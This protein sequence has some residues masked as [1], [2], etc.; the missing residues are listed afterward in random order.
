MKQLILHIPHSSTNIP[1]KDGYLVDDEFLEAEMLKLTD[2]HTDDLFQSEEDISIIANFSRVFC[3]PERFSDDEQ[4]VMAKVGMGVLY[5][6]SDA[7]QIIRRVTP[8][9]RERIL[10]Q[11]YWKHHQQLNEAVR[12]QLG[13][14]GQ[15]LII[16][17]HS[18]PDTPLLRDLH[19]E[20][21]RPDFN[22][23]T[24]P[25]HTPQSL[26]DFSIEFFKNKGYSLGVDWP[27]KG[28]IVPMEYYQKDKRVQT[29]MLEVNRKLYLKEP[30]NNKSKKYME[31]KEVVMDYLQE[32]KINL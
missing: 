30:S 12:S 5:E 10:N 24:D 20:T 25:Y 4:E 21:G 19:Q 15:T 6:R 7:G 9:L 17:C 2:W 28:S 22:I 16:D 8:E 1:L 14:Y 18:Y 31:T 3:D 29:I 27:Y 13:K 26:I 11:Y 23:G 32:I